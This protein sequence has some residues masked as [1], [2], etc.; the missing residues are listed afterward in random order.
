MDFYIT[1]QRRVVYVHALK[2]S[3]RLI[4]AHE[5]TE[6][7]LIQVITAS[8]PSVVHEKSP[9]NTFASFFTPE[10]NIILTFLQHILL[11]LS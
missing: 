2:W 10:W 1:A 5:R 7:A 9:A 4:S 11:F 3:S 6:S 8:L